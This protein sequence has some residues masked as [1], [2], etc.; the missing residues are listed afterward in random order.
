[1]F[2]EYTFR[3][4]QNL[5]SLDFAYTRRISFFFGDG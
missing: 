3:T 2:I 5:P 4:T 1:L